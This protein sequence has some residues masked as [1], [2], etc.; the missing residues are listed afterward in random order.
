LEQVNT[1]WR[2]G[3]IDPKSLLSI[4]LECWEFLVRAPRRLLRVL[5]PVAL[6]RPLLPEPVFSVRHPYPTP[7]RNIRKAQNAPSSLLDAPGGG[8]VHVNAAI[9]PGWC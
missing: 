6:L 2:D 3:K 9:R 8:P 1:A 7:E 5:L 4:R